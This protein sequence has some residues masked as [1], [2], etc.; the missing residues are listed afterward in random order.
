M[1]GE[2]TKTVYAHMNKRK[3][4]KK[5]IIKPGWIIDLHV[6]VKTKRF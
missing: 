6:K 1:G 2:M 3:E 5:R 4:K